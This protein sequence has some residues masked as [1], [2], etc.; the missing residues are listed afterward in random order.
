[1]RVR[2]QFTE[3]NPRDFRELTA[4]AFG[5]QPRGPVPTERFRPQDSG[6][7]VH[8][9]ELQGMRFQGYDHYH[10]EDTPDG[11]RFTMWRDD[12]GEI[13]PEEYMALVVDYRPLA[14][15][16]EFGGA[17]NTHQSFTYYLPAAH[18]MRPKLGPAQR[19]TIKD[20]SEFVAPPDPMH[21]IM[22]EDDHHDAHFRAQTVHGWRH[23]TEGV[24]DQFQR[25]GKVVDQRSLGR[26]KIPDGTKTAYLR[27]GAGS[28]SVGS[29]S[30]PDHHL[31]T[32]E[33]TGS[34]SNVS[35]TTDASLDGTYQWLWVDWLPDGTGNNW[36]S[37]TY[38]AQ[39]DCTVNDSGGYSYG[40]L[41]QNGVT[42]HF[43]NLR[44]LGA[45]YIDASTKAQV[46]SAF[47]GTGLKLATTGTWNPTDYSTAMWEVCLTSYHV[48]EGA[49]AMGTSTFT[50]ELN[51]ADDYTDGPW[52]SAITSEMNEATLTATGKA[53]AFTNP[54][55]STLSKGAVTATAK[56][57]SVTNAVTSVLSKGSVTAGGKALSRTLGAL[58]SVFSK[59]AISATGKSLTF[60]SPLTSTLSKAAVTVT[61]KALATTAATTSV[62]SKAALTATGKT[63][64]RVLGGISSTFSKA[65]VT[66]TP[67]AMDR[68]LGAITPT[69][70]RVAL[71]ATP[72]ALG[73]VV[74][75]LTATLG[76]AEVTATPKSLSLPG[77]THEF[78]KGSLGIWTRDLVAS[79]YYP[80][81]DAG[82]IT[83]SPKALSI[84]W[85]PH[86]VVIPTAELTAT[87]LELTREEHVLDPV[88]LVATPLELV[89]TGDFDIVRTMDAARLVLASNGLSRKIASTSIA[90]SYGYYGT[91]INQ[92]T[93]S[94]LVGDATYV[95]QGGGLTATG[96]RRVLRQA[97]YYP[98]ADISMAV[99][100]CV[101]P[102]GF[103]PVKA[104][105]IDE[106]P[107]NDDTD[108]LSTTSTQPSGWVSLY[109]AS[110]LTKPY[111]TSFPDLPSEGF[112]IKV[113]V[114]ARARIS[115]EGANVDFALWFNTN[116]PATATFCGTIPALGN[117]G[118]IHVS[119]ADAGVY[120]DYQWD[121]DRVPPVF[122]VGTADADLV[123]AEGDYWTPDLVR[124]IVG[125]TFGG[126]SLDGV[127]SGMRWTAAKVCVLY[128]TVEDN[129][130]KIKVFD[131][132]DSSWHHWEGLEED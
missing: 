26:Y 68:V 17:Y 44:D 54:L 87:P 96:G 36:P 119:A 37:G 19:R 98:Y 5:H 111:L 48:S 7:Y 47:T 6:R 83:A 62:M 71:T 41:T 50:L 90:A 95:E 59:A 129:A 64:V 57:L 122:S 112:I 30:S 91:G 20:W 120:A 39:F 58:V 35:D 33:S 28:T 99:W 53:L 121:L 67:K 79:T 113:M 77:D 16:P 8:A 97:C 73:V 4:E 132:Q 61:A 86:T 109:D 9:L 66:A 51:E 126:G 14:P 116:S 13:P 70:D 22:V 2:V 38:R 56:Q 74:G 81:M 106:D 125:M 105:W 45:G 117:L 93:S 12:P 115:P 107:P 55:T 108:Y 31:T 102:G 27:S 29:H 11:V 24:P 84:L 75:A 23:A 46:E 42:G 25:N 85:G 76:T 78:Y 63:L 123:A 60:T 92:L 118:Q 49:H 82:A 130:K 100:T 88:T 15:D 21:G 43:A 131:S 101:P 103:F 128:M 65:S 69:A 52:A 40:A 94:E 18:P 124:K 34:A 127:S 104:R 32:S 89:A 110:D 3:V 1:V 80:T 10:V 114:K 72:L